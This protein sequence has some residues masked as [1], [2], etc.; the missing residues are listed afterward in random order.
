MGF[1]S[2]LFGTSAPKVYTGRLLTADQVRAA[3]GCPA[4]TLGKTQYAEMTEEAAIYLAQQA[5][6][7]LFPLI[8]HWQPDASCTLYGGKFKVLANEKFAEQSFQDAISTQLCAAAAGDVWFTPDG[9]ATGHAIGF[10]ITPSGA[11]YVDPQAPDALRPMSATELA[12]R[13][14]Q[15]L[16]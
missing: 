7:A 15:N 1:F 2:S 3:L 14:F 4:L 11:K 8:G 12:S 10:V 16:L 13:Y 6:N 5:R 9:S